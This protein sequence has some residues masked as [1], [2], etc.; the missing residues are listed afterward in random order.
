NGAVTNVIP[1]TLVKTISMTSGG[2]GGVTV[3]AAIGSATTPNIKLTALGSG[4]ITGV[5][6]T[7]AGGAGGTGTLS[8]LLGAMGTSVLSFTFTSNFLTANA[9]GLLG[10]ANMVD[11]QTT[12][13]T[14]G[15]GSST[16]GGTFFT[17][18]AASNISVTGPVTAV[19]AVTIKTTAVNGGITVSAPITA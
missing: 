2:T 14:I 7:I 13:V 5:G 10:L 18:S 4:N 8:P 15:P 1:M 16:V 3:G 17:L 12:G 11:L 6:P 9:P 19:T